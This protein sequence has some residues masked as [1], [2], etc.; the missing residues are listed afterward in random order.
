MIPYENHPSKHEQL[1]YL[2]RECTCEKPAMPFLRPALQLAAKLDSP[3]A[4]LMCSM[5]PD[6]P[7]CDNQY[8]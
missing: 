1:G 5:R 6:M 2:A 4:V 7:K 8:A 3:N